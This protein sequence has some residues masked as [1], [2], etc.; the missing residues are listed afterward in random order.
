MAWRFDGA[1]V[2][3][4]S[5]GR[6]ALFIGVMLSFAGVAVQAQEDLQY[7]RRANRYEGIKAKPVSGFDIE[8]LSARVDFSDNPEKLGERFHA[9]FF[10]ERP[11]EVHLVVRELDYKHFY[12]LDRVVTQSPWRPGF[13]N[14]FDWPTREVIQQL[15]DLRISDL[16][17]VARLEREGP[18]AVEKV[19]PVVFYQTQFPSKV[20][21]YVFHFRLREDAK[22]KGAI[23]KAA[24]SDPVFSQDLGKQRGSRPFAFRWD[25]TSSL[26][27]EGLYKLVL[28]G[29]MLATNDPVS[30]IV[31]FYHR[32]DI[33]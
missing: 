4:T 16:G 2:R 17:V 25:V 1:E 8:L 19:A 21:G 33:K 14:V 29:Y 15:D 30:Q 23:Y 3:V 24:A 7:Q 18:S 12:W 28:S 26:A 27:Q 9:R 10:L 32:T 5:I 20:T 6:K 11:T 13:G 22:V 31:Q